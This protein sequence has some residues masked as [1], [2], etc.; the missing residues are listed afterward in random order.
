M[1][2]RRSLI[3]VYKNASTLS[4]KPFSKSSN[5]NVPTCLP[6]CLGD[7][8]HNCFSM[9]AQGP[10]YPVPPFWFCNRVN[11]FP[12]YSAF[13]WL[14]SFDFYVKWCETPLMLAALLVE[15]RVK[16]QKTNIK[17]KLNRA[18]STP[19]LAKGNKINKIIIKKKRTIFSSLEY[20]KSFYLW[21]QVLHR[22]LKCLRWSPLM[23]TQ[24]GHCPVGPVIG[25]DFGR[26]VL[27]R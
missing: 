26:N 2:V 11:I 24:N 6:F 16:S 8:L 25:Q 13:E 19:G 7:K 10:H 12:Q 17:T 4:A 1:L 15:F 27:L 3:I 14:Q 5:P 20:E 18:I 9:C 22:L 21:L 23:V